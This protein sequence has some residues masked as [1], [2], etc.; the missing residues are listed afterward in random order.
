MTL[1]LILDNSSL[2]IRLGFCPSFARLVSRGSMGK[3]FSMLLMAC[4]W[5][6]LFDVLCVCV[7][8]LATLMSGRQNAMPRLI[9]SSRT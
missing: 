1:Y 3:L 4:I 6:F 5:Y 8:V 9:K 2:S 7:C